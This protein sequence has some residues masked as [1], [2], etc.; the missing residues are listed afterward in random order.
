VPAAFAGL[1]VVAAWVQ[2]FVLIVFELI[3]TFFPA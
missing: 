1:L 2:L 3:A